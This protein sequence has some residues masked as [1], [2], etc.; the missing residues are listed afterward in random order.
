MLIHRKSSRKFSQGFGLI[1]V[2]IA[3]ALLTVLLLGVNSFIVQSMKAKKSIEKDID[4]AVTSSTVKMLTDRGELCKEAFV[5]ASGAVVKIV[6]GTNLYPLKE[7]KLGS[8]A[9]LTRDGRIGSGLLMTKLDLVRGP[10][11]VPPTVNIDILDP[12]TGVSTSTDLDRSY[13]TLHIEGLKEDPTLGK[14]VLSQDYSL[15]VLSDPATGGSIFKCSSD[16]PILEAFLQGEHGC[17]ADQVMTGISNGEVT[18]VSQAGADN[19]LEPNEAPG[20][21]DVPQSCAG[22]SKKDSQFAT[23]D[24]TGKKNKCDYVQPSGP[25]RLVN[26]NSGNVVRLCDGGVDVVD[27]S[28]PAA[29]APV[30]M[31]T[32]SGTDPAL[33]GLLP[34]LSKYAVQCEGNFKGTATFNCSSIAKPSGGGTVV[35]NPTSVGQ[36][37]YNKNG[38][39]YAVTAVNANGKAKGQKGCARLLA[40]PAPSP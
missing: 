30:T 25:W 3:A 32:V 40:G 13:F 23:W 22:H 7:I 16:N 26:R 37:Y 35:P 19:H 33:T 8:S 24:C 15:E 34:D 5:D 2:I 20:Q 29:G 28:P 11:P 36:C 10:A 9:L 1:E 31:V 6:A 4:F 21:Y 18:C 12:L 39:W 17:A 38:N 27:S 14:K